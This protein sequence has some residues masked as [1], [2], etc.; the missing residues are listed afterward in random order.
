MSRPKIINELIKDGVDIVGIYN[1]SRSIEVAAD[2]IGIAYRT[3]QKWLK[4]NGLNRPEG[5]RSHN[6][7]KA[8]GEM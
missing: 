4:E 5:R 6:E 1:E 7:L 8:M 3:L 2:R